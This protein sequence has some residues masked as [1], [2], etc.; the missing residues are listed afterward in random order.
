[1]ANGRI[2]GII[3]EA[4]ARYG[5]SPSALSVI[6]GIESNYNPYAK[7]PRS[8]AGGLFQFIDA[9][10]RDYGLDNRFDP[11][12]ASDAAARLAR[13]NSQVLARVLGRQPTAGELYLAHQQGAGGASKLLENPNARA[14]DIVGADSVR[15]NGGRMDMSAQEFA[16]LWINKANSRMGAA[17]KQET[18]AQPMAQP[19]AQPQQRGIRGFL[20]NP[21]KRD[22]L[23]MALEGMTLNP[24]QALIQTAAQGIQDRRTQRAADAKSGRTAEWLRANGRPDLAQAVATGAID[25]KSAV[26]A[27]LT[28][29]KDPRTAKQ[30]DYEFFKGLG[31][32]DEAALAAVSSGTTVNVGG[33]NAL[34]PG[35][36]AIDEKTGLAVVADPESP[37]GV[38]QVP[39]PGGPADIERAKAEAESTQE[40]E[41]SAER[42]K[43]LFDNAKAQ[44]D[45]V[46]SAVA[47]AMSIM[48]KKGGL[49]I[50]PEAGILGSRLASMG[51]NQQAVDLSKSLNTVKAAVAF[52]TLQKMREASKT[53]G[54][55]G[56]VSAPELALLESALGSLDQSLS[57][58]L[59]R[60]NL[61]IV[62]KTMTKILN[63]PV[64]SYYYQNG[65]LPPEGYT[66]DTPA[67]AAPAQ[68][69]QGI[70]SQPA[71][72]A[73]A[74]SSGK[75]PYMGMTRE[76]F[77]QIDIMSLTPEQID[78]LMEAQGLQ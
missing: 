6:A 26:S 58:D 16:N 53:G 73:P 76:Q 56:A 42:K 9:T 15:L 30:K 55:L 47:D 12:Q 32:S 57:E 10:A 69:P 50:L 19:T 70:L 44:A 8:S 45:A 78:Q 46:S 36:V 20:A 13:D 35:V 1:M 64:A 54:A 2:G 21:D 52:G 65:E 33:E 5:V 23:I 63:D 38:R 49:D 14:V 71:P 60:K 41:L 22:R 18:G 67:D 17:P 4:A 77:G 25:P 51:L 37:T 34:P 68:A 59:L 24:N 72:I 27:A 3:N 7:N 31:M 28:P 29:E 40:T 11:V 61:G 43:V 62:E 39:I 66:G 75:N 74:G 48:D